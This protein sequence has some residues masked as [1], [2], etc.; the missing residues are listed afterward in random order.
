[1]LALS[2]LNSSKLQKALK[3]SAILVQHNGLYEQSVYFDPSMFE[4]DRSCHMGICINIVEV[5]RTGQTAFRFE[6]IQMWLYLLPVYCS[7]F[8]KENE[9]KKNTCSVAVKYWAHTDNS[10]PAAIAEV[11]DGLSLPL[12]K[13]IIANL[14][15]AHLQSLSLFLFFKLTFTMQAFF[16]P[17]GR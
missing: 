17:L 11:I 5:H 7:Y 10:S 12:H 6:T 3:V 9:Q 14:D 8:L 1:M 15:T 4:T 13:P 2:C 16:K